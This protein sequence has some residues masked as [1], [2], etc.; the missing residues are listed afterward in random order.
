MRAGGPSGAV[1][2]ACSGDAHDAAGG[3]TVAVLAKGAATPRRPMCS[4]G[5]AQP[6][7]GGVGTHRHTCT[8]TPV[9]CCRAATET[10][11]PATRY[12]S[13]HHTQVEGGC[14][15]YPSA[16]LVDVHCCCPAEAQRPVHRG[17]IHGSAAGG[18]MSDTA[19]APTA[20]SH[21]T[22]ARGSSR[23]LGGTMVHHG[24]P[25]VLRWVTV[26]QRVAQRHARGS[27]STPGRLG[28]L[29]TLTGRLPGTFPFA[30]AEQHTSVGACA[31]RR[32]IPPRF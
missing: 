30:R 31:C 22:S 4:R 25:S 15:V 23:G 1:T 26:S 18:C 13:M 5:G 32:K 12:N 24:Q 28:Q 29:H 27:R 7:W 8:L 17:S 21:P 2:R 16:S 6:G 3:R 10:M 11:L 14:C 9:W 20:A 19:S